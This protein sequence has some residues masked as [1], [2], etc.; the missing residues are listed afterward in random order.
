V[1]A[2]AGL[3]GGGSSGSV[4]LTNSGLLSLTSGT[5]ITVGTGQNPSVT[6]NTAV[7]PQLS[8]A[9]T[10]TG[11]QIVNGNLSAT[12]LVTGSGFQIG[13]NL[14]DFGSYANANAV[15][16]FAGNATMTGT[17]NTATGAQA[18]QLNS[19]GYSNTAI[20]VSSLG[21]NT[22][23]FE[24]TATGYWALSQNTIGINNTAAGWRALGYNTVGANNTGIGYD[25]GT[26]ADNSNMTGNNN[27]FLG[28]LAV[29]STG[30]LTNATA[31]GANSEVAESNALVLGDTAGVNGAL[32]STNVGIGTTTPATTLDV[33]GNAAATTAPTL[34]LRNNAGIQTGSTGNS[35]DIRFNP[36]GGG[37]VTAPNA[38]IRASENGSDQYGTFMTFGTI[39]QGG[40]SAAER[41]RITSTGNVGIGTTAPDSLLSVNGSADKPG[42]GSW[43]TFSDRRL[44]DLDGSFSSGLQEI[45]KIH[46]VKYRYKQ[47]NGM[48]ISDHGEHVG[49]VAQ[50]VKE[51]IPEAV[52]ENN[53]GYLMVNTDP[54]IWTMLN[55]I[56]EQ[57]KEIKD[58]RDEITVLRAQLK[59]RA[60]KDAALETRLAKL[61]KGSNKSGARLVSAKI[62]PV[63]PQR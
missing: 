30:T 20:G 62:A 53:R 34:W 8:A 3:S 48:G 47:D 19:T 33:E 40:S 63:A 22:T 26:T 61:E 21:A 54:V 5:G 35:V 31:I 57:Q 50:E 45:L 15:T 56:K 4:T 25:A 60:A 12:G 24:N 36:D 37:V 44:K 28:L 39:A 16:G 27:T 2:G 41:I 6:I 9:N 32:V 7:V 51:V 58:Q 11:N 18:L 46:P 49:V 13:S 29:A 14:F 43:A 38:Y 55:A 17:G 42:G 52:T 23:G 10:F 1:T 59:Q